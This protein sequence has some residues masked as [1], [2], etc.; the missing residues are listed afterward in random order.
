MIVSA[1]SPD[2][3]HVV[4]DDERVEFK[5]E[6]DEVYITFEEEFSRLPRGQERSWTVA[7]QHPEL[8]RVSHMVAYD[9][10]RVF[11]KHSP[12]GL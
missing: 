4:L 5:E 3:R 10:N 8:N 1:S 6:S 11:I 7:A 12:L 2:I 9:D